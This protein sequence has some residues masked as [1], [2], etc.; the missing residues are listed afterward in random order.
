MIGNR[1]TNRADKFN[2]KFSR[3]DT[4]NPPTYRQTDRQT[5]RRMDGRTSGDSKDR[6]YA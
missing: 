2:D 6:T 5:D 3:V 4:Y 1:R